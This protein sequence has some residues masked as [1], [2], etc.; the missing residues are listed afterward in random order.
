MMAEVLLDLVLSGTIELDG[1]LHWMI[2]PSHGDLPPTDLELLKKR[3][4]REREESS[5][6]RDLKLGQAEFQDAVLGLIWYI[7]FHP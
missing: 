3:I 1:I 4:E 2:D 7:F 6:S 5:S